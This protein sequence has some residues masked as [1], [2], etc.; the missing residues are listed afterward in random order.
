MSRLSLVAAL[1]ALVLVCSGCSGGSGSPNNAGATRPA[2]TTNCP[3]LGNNL[4]KN[5]TFTWMY[6]VDATSFDKDKI[7]SNN[8][9]M[10]L[11]PISPPTALD[12]TIQAQIL[13]LLAVMR[14]EVGTSVL[15][16][17]HDL[18]VVAEVCDRVVVMYAGQVV[19]HGGAGPL[20]AE[21]QHP[22]TAGLLSAMPQLGPR[23]GRLASIPGRTP[24]PWAMPPGCRFQPRCG[25]AE[26]RCGQPNPLIETGRGRDARCVRVTELTLSR[27]V[28]PGGAQ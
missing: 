9:Q 7:T 25:F 1:G 20:F 28:T 27:T 16:I 23:T 19:K 8:S 15:F 22:Y 24:E 21:P 5:A 26:D 11:Y 6:S 4:D 2:T 18:S 13:E 10:Y 17:T 3:P 12:V 14:D